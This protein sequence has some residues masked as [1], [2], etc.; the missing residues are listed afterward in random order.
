MYIVNVSPVVP[1]TLTTD[2]WGKATPSRSRAAIRMRSMQ[3]RL[4]LRTE[5]VELW[6]WLIIFG[7]FVFLF[8]YFAFHSLFSNL[9]C[10][11][12]SLS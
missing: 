8:V 4:V 10:I 12:F 9:S 3:P 2:V 7:L 11:V 6:T 1:L 5:P